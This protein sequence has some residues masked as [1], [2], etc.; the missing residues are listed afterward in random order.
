[1]LDIARQLHQ[2]GHTLTMAE[3]C[4]L[5]FCR[6]SNAIHRHARIPHPTENEEGFIQG[7]LDLVDRHQIDFLIPGYDE[8]FFISK[9]KARF[10]A[11]VTVMVEEA[12]TI[13]VLNN[14]FKFM[15][16]MARLNIVA[17]YT[18]LTK[19]TEEL[20]KVLDSTEFN[21]P[22]IVKSIYSAGG[23]MA[24]TVRENTNI[25]TL[26][27]KFPCIV[28]QMI[29]G[30]VWSTYS[31]AHKGHLTFFVSYYPLHVFRENGAAICF[32]TKLHPGIFEIVKKIV[33]AT[34]Y[35]GQI[36]FDI[37]EYE[38]GSLWPIECN[39]RVTSGAHLANRVNN[40]SD[41]L[42]DPSTHLKVVA[43]NQGVQLSR[44]SMIRILLQ[45][46]LPGGVSAWFKNF[47]HSRDVLFNRSDIKPA[48]TLPLIGLLFF[49]QYVK[50]KKCPEE[51]IFLNKDWGG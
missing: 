7:L 45:S 23:L 40:F 13:D 16:L 2:A 4:P 28:Q 32:E 10:P 26:G 8:G 1:M 19:N 48:L 43:D 22:C 42:L 47:I 20:K 36:G 44:L 17:P 51:N 39:P 38:D 3:S 35:T 27:I 9:H 33:E 34:D 41:C 5:Y 25:D 37:I 46:K 14:K 11:S 21:R 50:Y 18:V 15:Q 49:H 24:K 30:R 31:I 12:S 29:P 6:F